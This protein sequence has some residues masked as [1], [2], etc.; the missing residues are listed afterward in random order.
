MDYKLKYLKYRAKYLNLKKEQSG[1]IFPPELILK[2]PSS[3][4]CK[5]PMGL[6][7]YTPTLS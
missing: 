2:V 7:F 1:G 4:K 3:A 5:T 6:T